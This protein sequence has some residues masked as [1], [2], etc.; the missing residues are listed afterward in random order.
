MGLKA[1]VGAPNTYRNQSLKALLILGVGF[2]SGVT[3]PKPF[4][5][6]VNGVYIGLLNVYIGLL[7]G[8]SVCFH[9][10]ANKKK[11]TLK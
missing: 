4:E 8:T 2:N 10:L 1:L 3:S 7:V 11:F 9:L 6:L 5:S